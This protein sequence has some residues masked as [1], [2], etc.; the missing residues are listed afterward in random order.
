M[1]V[2]K[3]NNEIGPLESLEIIF[4]QE[5]IKEYEPPKSREKSSRPF[6]TYLMCLQD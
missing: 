6:L 3:L 2:I 5:P 1:E 4:G